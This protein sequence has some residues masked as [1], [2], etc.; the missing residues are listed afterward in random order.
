VQGVA[1]SNPATPTI[2]RQ[3]RKGLQIPVC[4]PLSSRDTVPGP[5]AQ[6]GE[7]CVRNAEVGSSILLR[8]TNTKA[9]EISGCRWNHNRAASARFFLGGTLQ[10]IVFPGAPHAFDDDLADT[11]NF[12][13]VPVNIRPAPELARQARLK[14]VEFLNQELGR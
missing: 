9:W 2:F 3:K 14:A 8:S 5:I 13:G 6:L 7:R 1:S 4:R 11:V 12:D 10:V